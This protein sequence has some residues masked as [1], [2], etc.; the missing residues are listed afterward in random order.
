MNPRAIEVH[1]SELVLH[2]FP[3]G[4]GGSI[5]DA[6]QEE[7]ARLLGNGETL[8]SF[9][10]DGS[11]DRLAAASVHLSNQDRVLGSDVAR[12]VHGALADHQQERSP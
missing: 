3:P 6:V 8:E 2:G 9:R 4:A 10:A 5:G 7:L 12:S 11:I 1:I